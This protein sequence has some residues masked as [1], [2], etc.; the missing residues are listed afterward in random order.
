[1][2]SK[3]CQGFTPC[4]VA[5]AA[6]QKDILKIMLDHSPD[7]LEVHNPRIVFWAIENDYVT[8]LQV[9]MY[10]IMV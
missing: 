8:L 7:I 1:M 3:D 6:G 10:V 2:C 9:R 4:M 5:I